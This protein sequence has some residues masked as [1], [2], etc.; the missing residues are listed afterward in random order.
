MLVRKTPIGYA[1][2]ECQV[3]HIYPAPVGLFLESRIASGFMSK[4]NR[5][6]QERPDEK[7]LMCAST[8][9]FFI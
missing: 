6:S 9:G 7:I 8:L 2:R 3:L 1:E 5:I 4:N